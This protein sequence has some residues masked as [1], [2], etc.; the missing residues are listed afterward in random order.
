MINL[1]TSFLNIAEFEAPYLTVIAKISP[2]RFLYILE[3]C[4]KQK[5]IINHYI[6]IV[7]KITI[8]KY[9]QM[10]FLASFFISYS[11][12]WEKVLKSKNKSSKNNNSER[13]LNPKVNTK[14]LLLSK[15]F[16]HSM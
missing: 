15:Y 2:A 7:T 3:T 14:L 6:E 11:Q 16:F 13:K 1:Y 9:I 5:S 4:W 10:T 8:A 12:H